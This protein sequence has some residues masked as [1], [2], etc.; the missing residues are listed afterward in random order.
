MTLGFLLGLIAY[1]IVTWILWKI[2]DQLSFDYI[3][4]F[5]VG[6]LTWTVYYI[7]CICKV[8]DWGFLD[9]KVI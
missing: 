4:V 1:V 8:I 6:W 3:W 7:V 9:I 2:T 5:W